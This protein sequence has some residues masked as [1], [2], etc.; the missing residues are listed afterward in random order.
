MNL[1]LSQ[2]LTVAGVVIHQD[3]EGRYSLNDLHSASG[4]GADGLPN[5]FLRLDSTLALI[6]A[7]S[8]CPDMG[9]ITPVDSRAGRYGETFVCKEIVFTYAIWISP[10]FYLNVIRTYDAL[11]TGSYHQLHLTG[12]LFS[13]AQMIDDN[14]MIE[15]ISI[16]QMDEF[17]ADA[18]SRLLPSMIRDEMANYSYL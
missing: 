5:K 15:V 16:E 2:N 9:N 3:A 18:C 17:I 11:V 10:A 13:A 14:E 6:D 12:D 8:N 4:V 7:I 1:V